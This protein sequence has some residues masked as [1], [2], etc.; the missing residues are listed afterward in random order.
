MDKRSDGLATS[1]EEKKGIR[2]C[3]Q[4]K[5][6]LQILT[7]HKTCPNGVFINQSHKNTI[8]DFPLFSMRNSKAPLTQSIQRLS[9][10]DYLSRCVTLMCFFSPFSIFHTSVIQA[11]LFFPLKTLST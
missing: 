11:C 6:T 3:F 7:L 8:Q 10:A 9:V 1:R 4:W 5:W 2:K